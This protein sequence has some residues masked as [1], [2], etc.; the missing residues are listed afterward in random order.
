MKIE[1]QKVDALIPYENNPRVN[2]GAVEAVAASIKE[3]KFRNP[4]IVDKNNVIIAGHTRLKAAKKLG[5]EE[6]PTIRAE[7]LTE[8]QVRAFRL[9]DNKTA[10]LAEW[11]FGLLEEE[12]RGIENI[13]MDKMG[14]DKSD[15][16][17]D[18]IELD[19]GEVEEITNPPI[20]VHIVFN[21]LKKWR[22]NEEVF[23]EFADKIDGINIS[24]GAYD[25][26]EKGN[27]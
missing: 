26:A 9:A 24:V 7:D 11:D 18:E 14:F 15:L 5:L 2:D 16:S 8:E 21:S 25:E 4:I 13:G 27:I 20:D 12:L 10:E 23:R 22:E 3:F 1:Y 19:A 6:V 17:I